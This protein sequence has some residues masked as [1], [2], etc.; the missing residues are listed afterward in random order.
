MH[1]DA[2]ITYQELIQENS[3]LKQRIQELESL[4]AELK[5]I[6][7]GLRE[8]EDR[9][10]LLLSNTTDYVA[11][12]DIKGNLLFASE[13]M[14]S[15]LGYDPAEL[16]GTSGFDRVHPDDRPYV[17]EALK[18][19]A[20]IEPGA[21]S[22]VEY[23]ASC[24]DGSYKWVELIGKTFLNNQTGELEIIATVRDIAERKQVEEALRVNDIRFNKLSS[25]VSGMIY[26]FMKRPD[27]SY[28]LPFTT[29][30]I[31]DIFGCS[32][33]DVREDFTPIA[34]VLWP[35]DFEA[36][37]ASIEYSA[38]HMTPWQ[39]EYR[40]QVPGRTV[41]WMF[42]QS[43]PEKMA[44]GSII[45]HGFI[46]DVTDLKTVQEESERRAS[47]TAA[48]N[49]ILQSALKA[50]TDVEVAFICLREAEALTGSPFGWVGEIN[51][52][53]KMDT[54]A[55]SDPGWKSCGIHESGLEIKDME[56]RGIFGWVL[57]NGESLLTND[58]GNHPERVGLPHGHP[59]LTAFLGVPLLVGG[60][61]IGM[62]ALGNKTGGYTS[63]DQEAIE[64]L[65]V[66]FIEALHRKRE[67]L[68]LLQYKALLDRAGRMV[69]FGGWSVRT[70]DNKVVWSDQV[71]AIHEM[72]PGFSPSLEEGTNF[73]A[74]GARERII[75]VFSDCAR[76]GLPYDEELEI[77]TARG[78]RI[79]I[80]TV[81]E[82]VRDA[83]GAIIA[84]EGAFQDINDRKKAEVELNKTLK[85]LRKALR[86]II[87][88]LV[89]A[90]EARDPYTAGHQV[91]TADL[92]RSIAME[93]K[94]SS[95]QVDGIR[96]AGSI[97]DIGKLSVPA[98]ILSKPT[99]LTDIEYALIKEHPKRGYELLRDV[100]SPWPLAQIVLQ[101]HERL[102]GS[103]YPEGLKGDEIILEARIMAVADVVE[104]MASHRPYRPSLGLRAALE[105]ISKNRSRLYDAAV[106]DA[107]LSLFH[108][109]NYQF[110][111]V[112]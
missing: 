13:A 31:E 85:N 76:N 84:V 68:A 67:A 91:R 80:R 105:E 98:E 27:G 64:A 33:Q 60:R 3:S 92:A 90:V 66:A 74:Q 39:C 88:V 71:A 51:P 22:K 86:T 69:R 41:R 53:G 81:G 23:R 77:I 107:C 72:P 38:A 43:T 2:G 42:G 58:P 10:Q 9:N 109:K 93:M 37:I 55:L 12:Y 99:K 110:Q 102:D 97:H 4:T 17:R 63:H 36:I 57:K 49:R 7:K 59:P 18:K 19:I 11:H 103:G 45:W 46:T 28:C 52:A 100:E 54:L 61:S 95:E 79:W 5:R 108:E 44:D 101:H 82:A 16:I 65:S 50:G 48:I 26:Q 1:D 15:M 83:A 21:V 34:K 106:V 70:I 78:N 40:V 96:M 111:P 35:E 94:L 73:Y 20:A 47:V 32:P 104:A 56:I 89:S 30:A 112:Q 6:E 24:H 14:R 8:N 75:A 29:A 87:Q 25:H 62:V